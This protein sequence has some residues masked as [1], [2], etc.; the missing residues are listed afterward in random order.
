MES[1]KNRKWMNVFVFILDLN[2]SSNQNPPPAPVFFFSS[3]TSSAS[4]SPPVL[5]GSPLWWPDV[6]H[7]GS[8]LLVK[9]FHIETFIA[10]IRVGRGENLGFHESKFYESL[11]SVTSGRSAWTVVAVVVFRVVGVELTSLLFMHGKKVNCPQ[12]PPAPPPPPPPTHSWD[13]TTQSL[14]VTS[15]WRHT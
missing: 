8:V 11:Y 10:W 4:P 12:P 1:E 6:L 9:N 2:V 15:T 3:L 5:L 13:N 7:L 14:S